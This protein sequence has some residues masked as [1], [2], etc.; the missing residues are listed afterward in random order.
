MS[1]SKSSAIAIAVGV[2]VVGFLGN[3]AVAYLLTWAIELMGVTVILDFRGHCGLA[4][5]LWLVFF[6]C[7]NPGARSAQGI[8]LVKAV[9][10]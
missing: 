2:L 7:G 4:I 3:L 5:V 6:Y 8:D 10:K 9:Q 1:N